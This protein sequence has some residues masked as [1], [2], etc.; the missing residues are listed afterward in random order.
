VYKRDEYW[1][2]RMW[3]GQEKKYARF[4]LRTRDRD[5]AIDKAKKYY[6]ELMAQQLAGK[7]HFSKTTNQVVEEYLHSR[8][9]TKKK[10]TSS[11]C[12]VILKISRL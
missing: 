1:Q 7:T 9:K 3:L 6:H 5:T 4:K 2:M 10:F 8:T 12:L 11:G